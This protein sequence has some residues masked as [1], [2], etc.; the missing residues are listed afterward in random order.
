LDDEVRAARQARTDPGRRDGVVGELV[1]E[2]AEELVTLLDLAEDVLAAHRLTRL[3]TRD[4]LLE[5]V[6]VRIQEHEKRTKDAVG[7]RERYGHDV[8]AV[9]GP[10][11]YLVNCPYC[12]SIYVAAGV[13]LARSVAPLW[14]RRAARVLAT[15]AV[16]SFLSERE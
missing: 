4:A 13:S 15:S 12:A 8:A 2:E 3:I 16:V 7:V 14:W 1:P 5:G 6:R 9:G 10:L 11:G